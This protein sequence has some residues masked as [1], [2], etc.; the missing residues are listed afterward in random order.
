VVVNA[1]PGD[2]DVDIR[3]R[4]GAAVLSGLAAT[5]VV[6]APDPALDTLTV[7]LLGGDDVVRL[8]AG[9]GGLIRTSANA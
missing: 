9:L 6:T 5:V 7:N 8:G 2:D 1:T 4:G 3:P